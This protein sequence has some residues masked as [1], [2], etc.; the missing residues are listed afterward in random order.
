M[1]PYV[2]VRQDTFSS[3]VLK[4][5]ATGQMVDRGADIPLEQI[6][7]GPRRGQ[8]Q[9]EQ[10]QANRSI[11]QMISGNESDIPHEVKATGWKPGKKKGWKGLVRGH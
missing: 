11:G 1:G 4:H 10:C 7:A 3:V 6:P 2:V 9:F 8:H 5:P